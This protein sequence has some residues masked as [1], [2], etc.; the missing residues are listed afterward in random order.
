MP[1]P[2]NVRRIDDLFACREIK[3]QNFAATG[4]WRSSSVMFLTIWLSHINIDILTDQGVVVALG[5]AVGEILQLH[6][7]YVVVLCR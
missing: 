3:F 2:V 7:K 6:S 1:L 5:V 4:D